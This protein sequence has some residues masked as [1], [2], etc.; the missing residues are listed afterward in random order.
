[1]SAEIRIRFPIR[2]CAIS[3]RDAI[4]C[5]SLGVIRHAAATSAGVI[6]F[7]TAAVNF[8]S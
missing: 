6:H 3:P 1:M 2:I 4:R 8:R 5:T 7:A